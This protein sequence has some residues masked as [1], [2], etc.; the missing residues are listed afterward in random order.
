MGQAA[1]EK[2]D[3]WRKV[4]EGGKSVLPIRGL[5]LGQQIVRAVVR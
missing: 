4:C 5:L 3:L 1:W 2:C